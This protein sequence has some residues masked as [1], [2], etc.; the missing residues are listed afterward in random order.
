MLL[1]AQDVLIHASCLHII[2]IHTYILTYIQYI[3]SSKDDQQQVI[4]NLILILIR[5]G[6]LLTVAL[7]LLPYACGGRRAPANKK[8]V[9][10]R[11]SHPRFWST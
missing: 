2:A 4:L 5:P 3:L 1:I 7:I 6:N 10:R 8:I 9:D 11:S